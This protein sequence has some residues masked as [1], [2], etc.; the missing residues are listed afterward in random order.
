MR[1]AQTTSPRATLFSF[2]S[3]LNRAYRIGNGANTEASVQFI[4]DA[5]RHMDLSEMPSRSR[6]YLAPE[7]ALYLKVFPV[8]IHETDC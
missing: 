3:T 1:P 7:A 6:D 5:V 4:E 2:I 8:S